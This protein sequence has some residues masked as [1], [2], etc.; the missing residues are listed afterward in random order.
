MAPLYVL[1]WRKLTTRGSSSGE[2]GGGSAAAVLAVAALGALAEVVAR[3]RDPGVVRSAM[4]RALVRPSA[5][6]WARTASKP[7]PATAPPSANTPAASAQA[8]M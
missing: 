1:V 8:F 2:T 6:A 7:A 4:A 3:A 5:L